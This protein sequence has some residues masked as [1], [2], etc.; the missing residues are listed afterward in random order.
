MAAGSGTR[1][2]E[3]LL[4]RAAAWLAAALLLGTAGCSG[5]P[6]GDQ[7]SRSFSDPAAAPAA[8]PT[9][10]PSASPPV[11][12]KPAAL[13]QQPE[14][15]KQPAASRQ[16]G[17]AQ[18]PATAKPLPSAKPPTS[19]AKPPAAAPAPYRLTLQLPAADPA[20][21]AEAVTQ[22]LRAA[23]L[24]FEVERIERV[25]EPSPASPTAAPTPAPAPLPR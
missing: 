1:S 11:S 4:Q 12:A 6:F 20:A 7:L 14:R 17:P 8:A 2:S 15:A 9:T 19:G 21:P 22:A 13:P 25:V 3:A 5:S 10:A 18:P 16:A 24:R 23:G